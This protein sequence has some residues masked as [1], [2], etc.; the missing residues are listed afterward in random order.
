MTYIDLWQ[1]ISNDVFVCWVVFQLRT[2]SS[3]WPIRKLKIAVNG[4]KWNSKSKL[5]Q[6][7]LNYQAKHG[8]MLS[9]SDLHGQWR[10][11]II[12]DIYN[13]LDPLASIM[14]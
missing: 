4:K 13:I 12:Y 2:P 8:R 9:D 11:D 5:K 6:H 1:R 14:K 3:D 10:C 7:L